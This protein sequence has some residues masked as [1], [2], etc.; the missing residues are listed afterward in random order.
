M[1]IKCTNLDIPRI[2]GKGKCTS[3]TLGKDYTVVSSH[4]HMHRIINDEG[5]YAS[6]L[7][8]RFEEVKVEKVVD[9]Q[10]YFGHCIIHWKEGGTSDAVIGQYYDGSKWFLCS[11]WTGHQGEKM[12]ASKLSEYS[13]RIRK[14]R[15]VR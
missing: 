11:N 2:D 14:I 12:V 5:D 6:Y 4:G 15:K 8:I 9:F 13:D 1:R 3:I 7:K 10:S